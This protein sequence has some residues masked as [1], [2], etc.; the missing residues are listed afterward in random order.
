[1]STVISTMELNA[2]TGTASV[3]FK[4]AGN[5]TIGGTSAISFNNVI[6]DKGSDPGSVLESNSSA[7][8]SNTGTLSITNGLFEITT[9]TFQFGGNAQV[10]IPATGGIWIHGGALLGGNFTVVNDGWI[11]VSSGTANFG[12]SSGNSP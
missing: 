8:I 5:S 3:S 11:R 9:G 6:I 10:N 7:A 1:M 4:G 2:G 12:N